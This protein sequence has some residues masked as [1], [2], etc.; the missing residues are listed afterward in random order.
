M[1]NFQSLKESIPEKGKL[2]ILRNDNYE[3]DPDDEGSV[4]NMM[5]D[6]YSIGFTEDNNIVAG[7]PGTFFTID[8]S[9]YKE[10]TF[11]YSWKYIE[12]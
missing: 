10:S 3:Y 7:G 11:S 9:T 4:S 12:E 2:F 5:Y 6:K 1:T 8:L